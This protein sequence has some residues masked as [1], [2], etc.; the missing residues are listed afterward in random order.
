MTSKIILTLACFSL[1]T[2]T[3]AEV[4]FDQDID[5]KVVIEQVENSDVQSISPKLTTKDVKRTGAAFPNYPIDHIAHFP[6]MLNFFN[7]DEGKTILADNGLV[8]AFEDIKT[9]N[10]ADLPI[11]YLQLRDCFSAYFKA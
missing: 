8:E 4:N 7:S 5:M 3:S 2:I 11:P 1:A 10:T 6:L 9:A